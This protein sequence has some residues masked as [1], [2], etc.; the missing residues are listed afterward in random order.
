M[1]K[2]KA[3]GSDA[4]DP[5]EVRI[6]SYVV[7]PY[8]TFVP[9]MPAETLAALT[10]EIRAAG[11]PT[12]E[13]TV[14]AHGRILDGRAQLRACL[15]AGVAPRIVQSP[16][17]DWPALVVLRSMRRTHYTGAQCSLTAARLLG[18]FSKEARER[19]RTAGRALPKKFPKGG[20]ATLA[21]RAVGNTNV[22]YVRH[23]VRLLQTQPEIVKLIDAG[24]VP[25][26]A[27][28][29]ALACLPDSRRNSAVRDIAAGKDVS[30][31]IDR[32]RTVSD[33]WLTPEEIAAAVT[34]AFGGRIVCDP[35]ASAGGSNVEAT[36]PYTKS[37]D[38]LDEK[39]PW[40]DRT[41]LNPPFSTARRW[42]E[43]ALREA[44]P[45]PD[46]GEAQAKRIYVLLPVRPDSEHQTALLNRAIDV[47]FLAD[48]VSFEKP[49]ERRTGTGRL[50]VMI[51][52]LNCTT[53]ELVQNG[54][55]G[56]VV[57]RSLSPYLPGPTEDDLRALDEYLAERG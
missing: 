32:R 33:E 13:V 55:E 19:Q 9:E 10:D 22:V 36:V 51:A 3:S 20:A 37:D 6:G 16:S 21:A 29:N 45:I 27:Q 44:K 47:L 2:A 25:R 43:R 46:S 57:R 39:K 48:R 15:A 14:D 5:A 38:G 23:A 54:L 18:P 50:S 56:V 26:M 40:Y 35:C 53:H 41:F 34:A 28:A 8:R 7:H 11:K 52:G 30:L 42:V 12:G 31:V 24:F 49:G 17:A 4:P 1:A